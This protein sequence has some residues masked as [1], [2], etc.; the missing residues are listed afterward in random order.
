MFDRAQPNA[1]DCQLEAARHESASGGSARPLPV[2]QAKL[3]VGRSNDPAEA[4]ADRFA[5]AVVDT[6][7]RRTPHDPARSLGSSTAT[8]IARSTTARPAGVGIGGGDMPVALVQRIRSSRGEPLDPS[9]RSSMEGATG[10][11]LAAVRV[12]RDSAVAPRIQA[13]AFTVGTDIHF[14]PGQYQPGQRRGQ[15][16]LSHELAH[17]VQQG[18]AARRVVRRYVVKT[19]TDGD[20]W[21]VSE[22]GKSALWEEEKE[23]G[24]TLFMAPD[25]VK[26]ANRKLRKAGKN[27][28]FVRLSVDEGTVLKAGILDGVSDTVRKVTPKLV[29]VGPDPGNKK[30]EEINAGASAD[31]DGTTA[32]EFAMWADCGRTARTIMGT[33]ST[34]KKPSARRKIGDT[35]SVSARSTSPQSY[36]D[37]YLLAMKPFMEKAENKPYLKKDVHYTKTL[38]WKSLV[39]PTTD[40][41]AKRLYWELGEDGRKAFDKFTATNLSANPEIGG[42]YTMA[43]EKEMPGFKSKGRTW[44]FHWAGVVAKDGSNNITLENYAVSYGSD[45]DPVKQKALQTLA[46]NHVNRSFDFQMY[47]TKKEGQTFH[48][49]HLGSGTHGNRASTF[50]V[51]V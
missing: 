50:A 39:K 51:K 43:T 3:L 36:T 30:L 16:L 37:I 12:H 20:T 14:A 2:L 40:K 21:R 49:E 44:N 10:V 18:G 29:T 9:T 38:L 35:E 24:R 5:D 47:G 42:A 45:P 19:D 46:Y 7:L 1:D 34:G 4:A 31:D 15:W 13:S 27:G 11:D 8:R 23:G 41:Q 17:V 22:S 48:E 33:D 28:S 26:K 6:L 32:A 25:L